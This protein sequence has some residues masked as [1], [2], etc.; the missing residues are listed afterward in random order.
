VGLKSGKILLFHLQPVIRPEMTALC[1]SRWLN[2][3]CRRKRTEGM[4]LEIKSIRNGE[5]LELQV[6]RHD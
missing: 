2:N 6:E 4:S 5:V 1:A 3:N